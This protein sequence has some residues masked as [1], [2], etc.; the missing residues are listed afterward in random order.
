MIKL[1]VSSIDT[2]KKCAKKYFFRYIEKVKV[3]KTK[4]NFTEFG[5]CAHRILEIFH[6]NANLET[7]ESEY[8][9]IMKDSFVEAVKEFDFAILNEQVWTPDGNKKGLLYL[10]ELM[11]EYLDILRRD[12]MP[13][14]IKNELQYSLD[15]G[16]GAIIRGFIDRI[17]YLGDG[18]YKVID[19]KTS[20]SP[21]YL[22]DFQLLVYANAVKQLYPDAKKVKGSYML[23]KHN[24][25][26]K[27]YD[28]SDFDLENCMDT[29]MSSL[30]SIKVEKKWS[31]NPT[32]L[33]DWCDYKDMCFGK[34]TE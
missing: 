34:W 8:T 30:G 1:S 24:F 6:E 12:G 18:V 10:R 5:S 21:K 25:K 9:K 4:W 26:E 14:V 29:V 32:R 22:N 16:E 20:K 17:D 11:Q 31:K 27:E 2:F 7:D 28:F 15:I 33:C 23:I 19:Y 3:D 13:N